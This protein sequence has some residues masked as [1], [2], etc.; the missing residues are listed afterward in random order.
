MSILIRGMEMPSYDTTLRELVGTAPTI[1][2]AEEG[3]T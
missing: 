3:E 2:P 1:I